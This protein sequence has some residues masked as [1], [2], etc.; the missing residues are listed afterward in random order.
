MTDATDDGGPFRPVLP[1]KTS[2]KPRTDEHDQVS[3][4]FETSIRILFRKIPKAGTEFNVSAN[5]KNV[6][7]AMLKA[8]P[9]LSV[10][11]LDKQSAYHPSHDEFPVSEESFKAFF[12]VH[13]P[14]AKSARRRTVTV[15][16]VLRS[17]MTVKAIK[18]AKIDPPIIDWLTLQKI[19]I[20]ADALGHDITHVVGHLL[21]IHPK[22]THQNFLK[23][24]LKED[25][26]HVQ[27]SPEEVIALDR[28][29]E[30]HYQQ[31]MDSGDDAITFV[32]PFELFPTELSSG[33]ADN[34]V[35]E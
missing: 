3:A 31:A 15:G 13:P 17:S 11:S 34:R 33:P 4:A 22:I 7:L 25:L 35:L 19:F 28:S 5:V 20:K 16:C 2:K 9:S 29:T 6:I 14:P 30:L 18:F 23:D 27:I 26:C 12:L 21:R 10:L 32:P 8:D 24:T 1:S